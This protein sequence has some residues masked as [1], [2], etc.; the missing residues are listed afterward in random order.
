MI[1]FWESTFIFFTVVM[2]VG[3]TTQLIWLVVLRSPSNSLGSC[4]IYL[5]YDRKFEDLMSTEKLAMLSRAN[6]LI[7]WSNFRSD[8]VSMTKEVL[9]KRQ[10]GKPLATLTSPPVNRYQYY[11]SISLMKGSSEWGD[12]CLKDTKIDRWVANCALY[13]YRG[14]RRCIWRSGPSRTELE[15]NAREPLFQ[16]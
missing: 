14:E 10:Y 9:N 16:N 12:L 7:L 5:R 3:S 8:R 6:V 15:T 4:P 11:T 1:K 2:M 13:G